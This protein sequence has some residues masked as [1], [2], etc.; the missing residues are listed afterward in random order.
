MKNIF[1]F[2]MCYF[3]K[4]NMGN[5][6]FTYLELFGVFIRIF[7]LYFA[8]AVMGRDPTHLISLRSKDPDV[9]NEEESGREKFHLASRVGD[10]G[11]LFADSRRFEPFFV[12]RSSN[13]SASRT[14]F[15]IQH[16]CSGKPFRFCRII[17][18]FC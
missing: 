1:F 7:L 15:W 9:R 13:G 3:K 2:K 4:K 5:V 8:V 10:L 6:K 12:I 16:S 14:L 11:F 18:C 17:G